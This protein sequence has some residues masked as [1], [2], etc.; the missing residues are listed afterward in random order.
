MPQGTYGRQNEHRRQIF[1]CSVRKEADLRRQDVGEKRLDFVPAPPSTKGSS[2][3][4][5]CTGCSQYL[6]VHKKKE[7]GIKVQRTFFDE[8]DVML[9]LTALGRDEW[10]EKAARVT[11]TVSDPDYRGPEG[12]EARLV[13]TNPHSILGRNS[14]SCSLTGAKSGCAHLGGANT[15]WTSRSWTHRGKALLSTKKKGNKEKIWQ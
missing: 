4:P 6:C 15:G 12:E 11:M 10:E 13:Q 2:Y 3:S 5:V 8:Q 7:K 1:Q 9:L 14:P